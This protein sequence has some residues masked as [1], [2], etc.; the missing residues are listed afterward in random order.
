MGSLIRY[1]L[2]PIGV[3]DTFCS[4]VLMLF[5]VSIPPLTVSFTSILSCCITSVISFLNCSWNA[6]RSAVV[7]V[8]VH[9]SAAAGAAAAAAAAAVLYLASKTLERFHP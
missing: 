7:T 6:I 8:S 9:E 1:G 3:A 5:N 4:A 2:E